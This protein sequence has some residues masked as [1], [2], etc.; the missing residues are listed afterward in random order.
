MLEKDMETWVAELRDAPGRAWLDVRAA[1][2][3]LERARAAAEGVTGL[4]YDTDKVKGGTPRVMAD[5]VATM[6]E[7]EEKL[8]AAKNRYNCAALS[9]KHVIE[10]A[11]ALSVFDETQAK[12]WWDYYRR[13][14]GTVSLQKLADEN[15]L[16]KRRVQYLIKDWRAVGAFRWAVK[17]V[18][19]DI[20]WSEL[21]S[22]I[23]ST[24]NEE[25]TD[26]ATFEREQKTAL[27]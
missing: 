10:R 3:N 5:N 7:A 25:M 23:D 17:S 21:E 15:G 27:Y 4:R 6:L 8:E 19:S 26:A 9:F 18:I 2:F 12:L 22:Y 1:R 16:T 13:G 14:G 20:D 24:I 11:L